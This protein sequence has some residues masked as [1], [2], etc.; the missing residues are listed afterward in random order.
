M[1]IVNEY[2]YHYRMNNESAIQKYRV[3]I[4]ANYKI[5]LISLEKYLNENFNQVEYLNRLNKLKIKYLLNC[6]QNEANILNK[7][8]FIE[9]KRYIINICEESIM[10]NTI[11][12]Y[13]SDITRKKEWLTLY[14]L[15]NRMYSLCVLW[16]CNKN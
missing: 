9:K 4:W 13:K 14:L 10:K 15:R 7:K 3:D 12:E 16:K 5:L 1:V 11:M 2:L 6:L 8:S